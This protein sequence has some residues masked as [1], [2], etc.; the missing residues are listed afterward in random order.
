MGLKSDG[1]VV[2]WGDNYYGQCTVPEPN[3][4]FIAVAAGGNTTAGIKSDGS[5]VVWGEARNKT[6]SIP[7]PNI[8]FTSVSVAL[9]KIAAIRGTS[10]VNGSI[11]LGDFSGSPLSRRIIASLT[12]TSDPSASQCVSLL[13]DAAGSYTLSS[14]LKPPYNIRVSSP[15]FLTALASAVG[16]AQTNDFNLIN[17]DADGDNQVNLFDIV[18]LDSNFNTSDEMADLD[19]SGSVNLFDYV[20]IDQ[21]FGAHGE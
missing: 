4:G 3:S 20:I 15:H 14:Y 19:G 1:S 5:L 18:A 9:D 12:S 21:N 16:T 11:I 6:Q 8:G 7:S 13:P 2:C 10:E 17:G